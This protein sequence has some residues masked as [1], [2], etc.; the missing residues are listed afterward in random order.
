MSNLFDFINV[1]MGYVIRFCYA[2]IPN[3]MLALLLFAFVI[4]LL[5]FPLGIKQQ[6][7]MVKQAGLKPRETA[8]RKRYAGRT[9][10]VTQQKMNEEV[11]K[12]Y[13]TENYNP[14]GGCLPL[15]IQ[16][17]IIMSLYG[18]INNPLKYLCSF[19]ADVITAI[20]ERVTQLYTAS[21]LVL[22]GVSQSVIDKLAAGKA[23]TSID[24]VTVMH[25][26]NYS[27]F[28]DLVPSGFTA[29]QLPDFTAFGG[30]I[31]LADVP[32]VSTLTILTLIPVLTFVIA[33]FSM[34]LTRKMTYTPN[35]DDPSARASMKIMD[36]TMPLFSVWIT[37]TVPALI[38]VYWIYQN[39]LS[40]LQQFILKQM[41]PIPKFT[42]ED[43]KIAE[44]EMNGTIRKEKKKVR[45]LHRID[46]EDDDEPAEIAD[47]TKAD[48]P[49]KPS[50]GSAL[51][52][53]A[54]IKDESDKVKPESNQNK[55]KDQPSD[56]K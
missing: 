31:N 7:N 52:G 20:T 6:K 47:S 28:S 23:L 38:G 26:A 50:K 16:L 25:G 24:I 19:S 54:A 41:Y 5:L 4:K 8:I 27:L 53:K 32:S 29:S 44:R 48:T 49:P 10:K 46:E 21:S 39:V 15:V 14:M 3:Y 2:I 40:T 45:S 51:L 1:P 18:V 11:M 13:Q 43:F 37:F 17:P 12:L 42:D 22:T 33:F 36:F 56:D 55:Q 9:D 30:L 34:R 35:M